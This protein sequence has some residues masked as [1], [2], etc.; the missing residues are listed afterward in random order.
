MYWA[1]FD[2]GKQGR[3]FVAPSCAPMVEEPS[4]LQNATTNGF[5]TSK[6]VDKTNENAKSSPH[7]GPL[8]Q[9]S[10]TLQAP[11]QAETPS[12]SSSKKRKLEDAD[13][14]QPAK[15]PSPPWKKFEAEG[16]S[17]FTVGGQRVSARRNKLPLELQPQGQ[18]RGSYSRYRDDGQ[19][20]ADIMSGGGE[21]DLGNSHETRDKA[22]VLRPESMEGRASKGSQP[23]VHPSP[24]AGFTRLSRRQ[25]QNLRHNAPT[26]SEST[27]YQRRSYTRRKTSTL[28]SEE[29]KQNPSSSGRGSRRR[30]NLASTSQNE[31]S[32]FAKL[33]KLRLFY[34]PRP[35]P[36]A[37]PSNMPH[38]TSGSLREY[39]R[40]DDP[41]EGEEEQVLTPQQAT[42]EASIR[43]RLIAEGRP[44]GLL[45]RDNWSAVEIEPSDE[46]SPDRTQ[47]DALNRAMLKL[48]PLI[49]REGQLHRQ[50]AKKTA[51]LA[52]DY[53][54]AKAKAKESTPDPVEILK[55]SFKP[56]IT[57]LR[58]AWGSALNAIK[59][60]KVNEAQALKNAADQREVQRLLQQSEGFLASRV[61][62][63]PPQPLETGQT[64]EE[65]D[66]DSA[67]SQNFDAE[68]RISRTNDDELSLEQLRQKYANIPELVYSDHDLPDAE[69]EGNDT[70]EGNQ[71]VSEDDDDQDSSSVSSS[72]VASNHG[73][74][75]TAREQWY[76]NGIKDDPNHGENFL[77]LPEEVIPQLEEVDDIL[78]DDSGEESDERDECESDDLD[79]DDGEDVD[80]ENEEH[81]SDLILGFLSKSE[82]AKLTAQQLNNGSPH[83]RLPDDLMMKNDNSSDDTHYAKTVDCEAT[84]PRPKV[85]GPAIEDTLAVPSTSEEVSRHPSSSPSV[86]DVPGEPE[87]MSS[88]EPPEK[89]PDPPRGITM[90]PD[91][92]RTKMPI[93]LRGQLREYQH[94]GLDWLAGMYASGTNG[95]LADEMGLGKTIQTIALLAHLAEEHHMW[96]PHLVV[97]PTSVLLNWEM[98][99]KKW[100]PGFK[101]LAY[102]GTQEERRNKRKGWLDDDRWHVC[103]TSYQLGIQDAAK[104]KR[105]NWHFLILDEAHNIKNFRSKRWQT[106]LNF[107]SQARLLL[108]GTPLQN[109]LTEL[110]SLLFFLAPDSADQEN[111][112]FGD[113]QKFSRA[114]HR[115]VEQILENGREGLDEGA[116]EI[117][118]KLHKVL[119]PHLLRRLK[120]DVE[121]Q[122]P[123]KYEHVTLCRLS[124]RQRQLYDSYMSLAGTKESFASGNY[125]SIIACLM[126]LRKVC[127]HPDL[128]ETRQIVT[129]FAMP[130]SAIADYEIKES[131]VRRK[132]LG[133]GEGDRPG[134]LDLWRPNISTVNASR[135]KELSA[136]RQIL[137]LVEIA[138]EEPNQDLPPD[139]S[140]VSSTVTSIVAQARRARVDEL[141]ANCD[142]SA[143]RTN[144]RP[145]YGSSLLRL[146]DFNLSQRLQPKCTTR[147][148]VIDESVGRSSLLEAMVLDLPQR[149][150]VLETVIQKFGFATPA[151][152][153]PLMTRLALT[154]MGIKTIRSVQKQSGYDPFHE[155]RIRLSIAFPDKGLVQYDCG[156][157]QRLE[158]LLRQL[159]AGGHRALIFTQMTKVLDI[160][161]RFL[162]LHG[163]RYLRLDGSTK[164]EER[165]VLTDRFNNDPRIPVFIL[166]SR[167][168][169]LGINLTGA[170]TV[171]FYDLDW[172]PAMDKQCQDRCHRIGQTRDVHIYRFVSEGT[173]EANILRKSNQKRMLDDVVI[174]EGDFTTE[175][176]NQLDLG[177]GHVDAEAD[178]ALDKVLGGNSE[179]RMSRVL[180]QAE[181]REDQEAAQTAQKEDVQIDD[182]DFADKS[183]PRAASTPKTDASVPAISAPGSPPIDRPPTPLQ[184]VQAY[185]EELGV[186]QVINEKRMTDPAIGVIAG[187]PQDRPLGKNAEGFEEKEPGNLMEYMIK[188]LEWDLRDWTYVLPDENKNKKKK[189]KKRLM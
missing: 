98:E 121:K 8:L 144:S 20:A 84:E 60:K 172:N 184:P 120:A 66:Q 58:H 24:K 123:K 4:L 43:N 156:K 168:G 40:H 186:Q 69:D 91:R 182:A 149:G 19:Q 132:L 164:I 136:A 129:S 125:M 32:T 17:A 53:H 116:R 12:G 75:D 114:F 28:S 148:A 74:S 145:M 131:V 15:K 113:L 124:R 167:S 61:K 106:L 97:V 27:P 178:A 70:D 48:G 45:G 54:K 92:F 63:K 169:G 175:Y 130:K 73:K 57:Q 11:P 72:G 77:Q 93:L 13:S 115:P 47:V 174:Q 89:A 158:R 151:V 109:N 107:R 64:D 14:S 87:S 111:A 10:E 79:S 138:S 170:D 88:V 153:A 157:L 177:G 166:S 146:L 68:N 112:N 173:I 35:A 108:T 143:L 59:E 179:D 38:K 52:L 36:I 95:I 135:S 122:M 25:S 23:F 171:I 81:R 3:P 150:E 181:D 49:L 9:A 7:N 96:G 76:P 187:L 189:K 2:V 137:S 101:I 62:Q 102:Y 37:H 67:Q 83:E 133:S 56:I 134:L 46:P 139:F 90:D 159:Q 94:D 110:W 18:T 44:G 31:Q 183:S 1:K 6:D 165:Q 80:E 86:S 141:R 34:Q 99:F 161:E 78:L 142:V 21:D 180:G 82:R 127:N 51:S 33:P 126:Q 26:S 176:F 100:C 30:N 117:V 105:K 155:A 50:L 104:L 118:A 22:K 188:F 42:K 154:D 5:A 128:F 16:P 140:T 162:N 163:Q 55:R 152:V 71:S 185:P 85:R 147:R 29:K 65:S 119:R 39:L 160:L 103:I 41:L